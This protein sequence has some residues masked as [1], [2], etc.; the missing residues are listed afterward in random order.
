[1][2]SAAYLLPLLELGEHDNG[3]TLPFPHHPPEVHHRVWERALSGD[4]VVLLS[5]ALSKHTH[6]DTHTF[7]FVGAI[8]SM[9]LF[10]KSAYVNERRIDV[11]CELLASSHGENDS[12][13]II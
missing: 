8:T 2:I 3:V 9:Q 1:M 5:V 4:E 6:T 10:Q 7:S 11:V 12:V 13:E